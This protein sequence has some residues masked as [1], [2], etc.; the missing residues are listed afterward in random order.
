MDV[1]TITR[2]YTPVDRIVMDFVKELSVHQPY[3]LTGMFEPQLLGLP[4]NEQHIEI[5]IPRIYRKEF[6][7]LF[8][9]MSQ[10]KFWPFNMTDVDELFARMVHQVPIRF[11]IKY[12][13]IPCIAVRFPHNKYEAKVIEQAQPLSFNGNEIKTAP[14][15]FYI[16]FQKFAEKTEH[17]DDGCSFIKAKYPELTPQTLID[18]HIAGYEKAQS[19]LKKTED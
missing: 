16:A 11:G 9:S 10:G 8:E 7:I 18:E 4:R 17:D 2:E 14:F 6:V 1:V 15:S 3:M 12:E 19:L 5:V 13:T